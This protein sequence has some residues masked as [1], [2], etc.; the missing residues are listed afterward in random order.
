MIYN[1]YGN[2]HTNESMYKCEMAMGVITYM[3]TLHAFY[4]SIK[5]RGPLSK[6]PYKETQYLISLFS[7]KFSCVCIVI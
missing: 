4:V 3:I 7:D 2:S 1:G 5:K 6:T